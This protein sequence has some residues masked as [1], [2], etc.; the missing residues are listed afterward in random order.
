MFKMDPVQM[1]QQLTQAA[2]DREKV[3]QW[4]VDLCNTET[5]E[6]ALSE[7]R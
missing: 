7:L 6:N 1:P 2:H 5:R 3:I 4:I